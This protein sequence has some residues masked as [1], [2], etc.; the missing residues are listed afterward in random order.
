MTSDDD[1]LRDLRSEVDEVDDAL[2]D[3]LIRRAEIVERIAAAKQNPGV[4]AATR[5]AREAAIMRRLLA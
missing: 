3:L 4:D 1:R 2:H 5:P